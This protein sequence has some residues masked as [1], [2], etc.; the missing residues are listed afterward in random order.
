[1]HARN[2]ALKIFQATLS[3]HSSMLAWQHAEHQ[4][5]S[6]GSISVVFSCSTSLD[7]FVDTAS[8]L[9]QAQ[10]PFTAETFSGVLGGD[11][12][13]PCHLTKRKKT[14][15]YNCIITVF[16]YCVSDASDAVAKM[17]CD[18]KSKG[19]CRQSSQKAPA[20]ACWLDILHNSTGTQRWP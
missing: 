16:V 1:M 9:L 14:I 8:Y 12:N 13:S 11:G 10:G 20:R 15:V 17:F 5:S 18:W 4:A 19:V 6:G 3:H 7:M 2:R